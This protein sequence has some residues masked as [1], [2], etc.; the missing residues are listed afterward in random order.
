MKSDIN[1]AKNATYTRDKPIQ[2]VVNIL[3]EVIEVQ[4]MK[5]M[6]E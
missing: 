4:I 6:R 2:E 5:Q 1:V 3:S